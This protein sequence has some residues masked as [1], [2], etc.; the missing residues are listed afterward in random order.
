MTARFHSL[1]ND[2]VAPGVA[3]SEP[4]SEGTDLPERQGATIVDPIDYRRIRITPEDVDHLSLTGR[5]QRSR[6]VPVGQRSP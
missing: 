6:P 1:R 5:Q 2:G 4:L 3:G